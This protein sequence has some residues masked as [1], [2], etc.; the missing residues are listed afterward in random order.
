MS[1]EEKRR[2]GRPDRVAGEH[3]KLI[4]F[5]A[6]GRERKRWERLQVFRGDRYLSDTI[7]SVLDAACEAA[8]ITDAD[9]DEG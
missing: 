6:T 4:G 3:T 9:T 5:N 7:R 1:E 2:R 8:G